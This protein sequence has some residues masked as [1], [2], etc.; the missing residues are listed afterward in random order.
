MEKKN[1]YKIV[2]KNDNLKD[3]N[4]WY[5]YGGKTRD[6]RSNFSTFENQQARS[7]AALVEK[8]TNSIDALLL[9]KCKQQNIDD[10]VEE[11]SPIAGTMVIFKVTDNCWHGHTPVQ[12]KR[13]SIQMNYLISEHSKNKHSFFHK[14]SKYIK[15]LRK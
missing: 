2:L 14:I 12:G 9:K 5:P 15:E 7:G 6:D 13:L 11:I 8:I 4:N 10:Y 3:P 1:L